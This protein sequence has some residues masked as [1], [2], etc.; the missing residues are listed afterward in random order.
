MAGFPCVCVL[1]FSFLSSA[2]VW[3]ILLSLLRVGSGGGGV[4]LFEVEYLTT[5][6]FRVV[7]AHRS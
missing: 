4:V 3:F 1:F 6:L 5:F 2:Y 7:I